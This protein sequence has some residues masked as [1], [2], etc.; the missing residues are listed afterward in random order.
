MSTRSRT[1]LVALVVALSAAAPGCASDDQDSR[2]A[3]AADRGV[4]HL[5]LAADAAGLDAGAPDRGRDLSADSARV[6]PPDDAG[7]A[8]I[9]GVGCC[10]GQ[11]V[12]WCEAGEI[13][14][15]DC[16]AYA[17]T[18]PPQLW[19]IR[20]GWHTDHERYACGFTEADPGGVYPLWCPGYS[21]PDGGLPEPADPPPS[22]CGDIPYQGCCSGTWVK[23]CTEGK[24]D[25]VDC[26][27]VGNVCGWRIED[28]YYACTEQPED[29]PSGTFPRDCP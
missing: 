19:K 21:P 27:E 28:G 5:D 8:M 10:Y 29:D 2:D 3:A 18:V 15:Q 9:P 25:T 20:C 24:V 4:G 6:A 1:L 7:C 12:M 22:E 13:K 11:L 23:W 14:T 16:A 17:D 26:S